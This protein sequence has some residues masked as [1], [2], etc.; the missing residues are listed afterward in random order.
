M[1]NRRK[2]KNYKPSRLASIE[3][4]CDI[5]LSELAVIRK[6]NSSRHRSVDDA[7]D[8]MH[9]ASRRMMAEAECDARILRR[10]FQFK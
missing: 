4:K 5:I 8:R 9:K 7:I 6:S 2:A 10:V 3:R 1:N